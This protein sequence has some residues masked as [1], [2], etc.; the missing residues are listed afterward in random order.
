MS[1]PGRL[2][3]E[4]HPADRPTARHLADHA[5]GHC[6]PRAAASG[7]LTNGQQLKAHVTLIGNRERGQSHA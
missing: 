6:V 4:H 3:P 5:R 2:E 1:R 7:A